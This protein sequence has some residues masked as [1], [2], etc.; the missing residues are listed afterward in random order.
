MENPVIHDCPENIMNLTGPDNDRGIGVW[1]PPTAS[2][3]SG[4]VTLTPTHYPGDLFSIGVTK[5]T[6]SAV[7]PSGNEAPVCCFNITIEGTS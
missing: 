7:D 4:N 2:D 1:S 6:Y 5:V 3:N